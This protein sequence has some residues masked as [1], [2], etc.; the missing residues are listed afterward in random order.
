MI[1]IF[2]ISD[3]HFGKQTRKARLLLEKVKEKF[4]IGELEN[5]Y[6]IVTGDITQDGREGQF[7][8]AKEA[9][10]PFKGKVQVVPGNH[11]YGFLGFIYSEASARNF[12]NI[13]S[14]GLGIGHT[15]FPKEPFLKILADKE[16]NK[17]LIIGLNSCSK[18]PHI[19]DI[20]AGDI[21]DTQRNKLDNILSNQK[22]K[23]IPK[24]IFLHHIPHK[25]AQGIGM[26][27]KDHRKLMAVVRNRVNAF[28]FGHEGSMEDVKEKEAKK[29]ELSA[30]ERKKFKEI[31]K[32][33]LPTR[34]MKIRSG[35]GQGI[36]YYLDANNSVEEIA[37]Y[38]I[39]VEGK[40]ILA[41][42]LWLS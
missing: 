33:S 9:L 19:F 1:E 5:K 13:L 7:R 40:E 8:T 12:D 39:K 4:K 21:E 15:Y 20:A 34:E 37:C 10:I 18:T 29:L 23:D 26:S 24:I 6:L 27:L 41:R 36:R 2:H 11:D 38:H 42:L 17:V 22:Y 16:G 3:L 32:M 30:Q 28:A 35:K 25:R 31:K 14:L